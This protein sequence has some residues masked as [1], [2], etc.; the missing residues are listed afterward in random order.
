MTKG[1]MKQYSYT[2]MFSNLEVVFL[3]A[4]CDP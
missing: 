4:G 3:H 2:L 1:F